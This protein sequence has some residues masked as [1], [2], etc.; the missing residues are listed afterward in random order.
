[1]TI[2]TT[3]VKDNNQS[4]NELSMDFLELQNSGKLIFNDGNGNEATLYLSRNALKGNYE[5][6]PIPPSQVFDVRFSDNSFVKSIY[7]GSFDV[8]IQ[9]SSSYLNITL[10]NIE[11][12]VK[13]Y[14]A[15]TGKLIDESIG[16]DFISLK[17][18]NLSKLRIEVQNVPV[19]FHLFQNY[20]NPF[21]PTTTITFTLAEDGL[22]TLKVYDVLGEEVQTIVSEF[23]KS[24]QIYQ[25]KFDGSKLSSGIYFIKLIQNNK[26]Q[27]KKILL[28]K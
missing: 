13:I 6:P 22:T 21:N 28:M 14:E 18:E 23:L 3:L 2:P 8:D 15:T 10:E 17:G 20:P 27:T 4:A 11:G 25:Y 26:S 16:K 1:M 9:G 12:N 19:E 5:L 24:G 7:D